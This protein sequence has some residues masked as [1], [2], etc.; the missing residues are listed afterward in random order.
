[1]DTYALDY[2]TYYDKSCSIKTRGTLGYFSHPEFDAYMVCVV[3]DE[4]TSFVGHPKDFEWGKLEGQ[5]VLSHNASF[6]ETL[7]L[8]GATKGWWPKIECAEWHCTADMA[9][10]CGKP[11]ALKGAI[12]DVLGVVIDKSTR[13]N[14]SGKRWDGMTE[15]FQ[16]E[17]MEYAL[18]DSEYSLDL[19]NKLSP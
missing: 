12:E 6:D 18:K 11:R 16:D 1:M 9:A 17:V 7:Y 3:G 15:E 10:Y 5:R 14:M 8:F 2:E 19:W 4:G 13:D